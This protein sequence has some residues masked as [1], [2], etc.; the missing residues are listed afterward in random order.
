MVQAADTT[1]DKRG[2]LLA[3]RRHIPLTRELLCDK[4]DVSEARLEEPERAG[5]AHHATA[6]HHHRLLHRTSVP[7]ADQSRHSGTASSR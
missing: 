3:H 6:D 2:T 5:H 4:G 7:R 1:S